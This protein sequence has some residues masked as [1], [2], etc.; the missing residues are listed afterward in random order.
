MEKIR[1]ANGNV[2]E[3]EGGA[4]ENDCSMMFDSLDDSIIV[5]KDFTEENLS[6]IEFLTD[7]NE[8]CGE[9]RNKRLANIISYILEDETYKV[10][11]I[12]DNVDMVAKRLAALESSQEIQNVAIEDMAALVSEIAK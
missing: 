10:A 2:Y 4:T 11:F 12:F 9:Y 1:L 8:V 5:A 6:K 3:I 7:A